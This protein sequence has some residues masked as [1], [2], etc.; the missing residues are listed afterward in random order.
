[1][2][3]ATDARQLDRF[4]SLVEARTG[5]CFTAG[6]GDD[7]PGL[8]MQRAAARGN[9]IDAYLTRL[10]RHELPDELQQ[11]ASALT[12]A[13]TYFFRNP[14]QFD[15]FRS[16]VQQHLARGAASARPFCVLSAGCASGEEP[17]SLAI[18]LRELLA[19]CPV[20]PRVLGVDLNPQVLER[21]RKAR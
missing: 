17:Y 2:S 9:G 14:A 18:S 7:L 20:A 6:R 3:E 13:E 12:V 8:L 11:L 21:A 15:A 16:L 4:R 1:M 10:E 5:L 19:G